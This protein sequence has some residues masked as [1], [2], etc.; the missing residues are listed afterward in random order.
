MEVQF[1]VFDVY[2]RRVYCSKG[3]WFGKLCLLRGFMPEDEKLVRRAITDPEDGYPRL[4]KDFPE[5]RRIY[6]R[7][8][9]DK[10]F[11]AKVVVEFHN[12]ENGIVFGNVISGYPKMVIDSREL[13]EEKP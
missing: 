6:Y 13:P 10:K 4:D 2:K 12:L 5:N 1:E 9:P 3:M 8:S 7:M 11:Y